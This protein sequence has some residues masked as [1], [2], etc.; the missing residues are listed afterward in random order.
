MSVIFPEV[1]PQFIKL[2]S[3][4]DRVAELPEIKEYEVSPRAV[5][6]HCPIAFF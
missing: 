1:L 2:K 3:L 4:R 6:S 5:T